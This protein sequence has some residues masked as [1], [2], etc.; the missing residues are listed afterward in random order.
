MWTKNVTLEDQKFAFNPESWKLHE[1]NE[2][3]GFGNARY[4]MEAFWVKRTPTRF[5]FSYGVMIVPFN[6]CYVGDYENPRPLNERTYEDFIH[7][8]QNIAS[9]HVS[10][11]L[12]ETG[13]RNWTNKNYSHIDLDETTINN[14]KDTLSWMLANPEEIPQGTEGWYSYQPNGPGYYRRR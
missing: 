9:T 6:T 1:S 12:T 10:K 3:L 14:I 5:T 4:L 13:I 11:S 7:F 2:Y 8:G